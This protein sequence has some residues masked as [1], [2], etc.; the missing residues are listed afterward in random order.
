MELSV[1]RSAH[2]TAF[3][4]F[5]SIERLPRLFPTFCAVRQAYHRTHHLRVPQP[6][7]DLPQ[8]PVQS[9]RRLTAGVAALLSSH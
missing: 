3:R 1:V 9:C 4:C 5:P 6:T 8:A 2:P 7:L